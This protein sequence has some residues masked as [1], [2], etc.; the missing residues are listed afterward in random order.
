[1]CFDAGLSTFYIFFSSMV[2]F[3]KKKSHFDSVFYETR[4]WFGVFLC[5]FN[6]HVLWCALIHVCDNLRITNGRDQR[7]AQKQFL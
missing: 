5:E 1:M 4:M 3:K 7:Q 2:F 6:V